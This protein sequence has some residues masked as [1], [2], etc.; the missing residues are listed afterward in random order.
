MVNSTRS[1][2][3]GGIQVQSYGVWI[4]KNW[5]EGITT[6]PHGQSSAGN[7]MLVVSLAALIGWTLVAN[8]VVV[9][10][11]YRQP[12]LRKICNLLVG[13]L[14]LTDFFIALVLMTVS[15]SSEY[16]GY[17]PFS[18]DLCVL[19]IINHKLIYTASIWST[20]S[21]AIDRYI[22]VAH[23]TWYSSKARRKWLRVFSYI[24][25]VWFISICTS[26]P[27]FFM[28]SRKLAQLY[29]NKRLEG[30]LVCRVHLHPVYATY[31]AISSFTAPM[32]LMI[33]LYTRILVLMKRQRK[34]HAVKV[35]NREQFD[36]TIQ[37]CKLLLDKEGKKILE[38]EHLKVVQSRR[39]HSDNLYLRNLTGAEAS[40]YRIASDRKGSHD[41]SSKNSS[42]EGIKF[43]WGQL[44]SPSGAEIVPS[45]N[46]IRSFKVMRLQREQR[47][48]KLVVML[49]AL[50]G[51]AWFPYVT[52]YLVMA[53][54]VSLRGQAH[55]IWERLGLWNG[56]L[57]SGLNPIAYALFN[58]GLRKA[59]FGCK[60]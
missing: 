18:A 36:E 38:V 2:S 49:I 48:L 27:S 50:L 56:Y 25:L 35:K 22:A 10:A 14:A 33:I 41:D 31:V 15:A 45:D 52:D 5:T 12:A 43:Y 40:E 24:S 17:W 46:K 11:L 55:T 26:V 59:M 57:N 16:L 21:I 54:C 20:T 28:Y 60:Q 37:A 34:K 47:T 58:Q 4:Q 9:T 53:Y 19:W 6:K 42:M 8:F 13:H 23:P 29:E 30:K 44:R 39:T 7:I 32:L 51:I 3:G 1:G